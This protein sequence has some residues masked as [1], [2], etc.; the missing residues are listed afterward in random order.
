MT[1][2]VLIVGFGVLAVAF[3]LR[4]PDAF[5]VLAAAITGLA[6]VASRLVPDRDRNE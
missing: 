2:I 5:A 4:N 6:M 1:A 3:G